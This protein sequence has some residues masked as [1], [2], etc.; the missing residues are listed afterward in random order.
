[1]TYYKKPD[2]GDPLLHSKP[3]YGPSSPKI[4]YPHPNQ[5]AGLLCPVYIRAFHE[6]IQ[7]YSHDTV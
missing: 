2:P 5:A 6:S 4:M 1:M 3:V 7:K